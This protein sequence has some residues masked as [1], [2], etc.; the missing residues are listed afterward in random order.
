MS[1]TVRTERSAFALW[2]VLKVAPCTPPSPTP[3][4]KRDY[5]QIQAM[6]L[7]GHHIQ[8]KNQKGCLGRR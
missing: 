1:L 6:E 5:G 8:M 3:A 4:P 7:I 2:V